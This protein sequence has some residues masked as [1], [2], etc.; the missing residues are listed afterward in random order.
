MSDQPADQDQLTNGI[1]ANGITDS[2]RDLIAMMT[3]G[4]ISELDLT[5]GGVSIRLRGAMAA[6]APASAPSTAVAAP[7]GPIADID[8]PVGHIVTSP[9]IGTFYGAPAPGEAPFVQVGDE[10]EAGQVIGII[11]AMKIMNEI[12][13][14]QSGILAEVIV[15]NAQ[16][17]EFGSP[18]MR[19]TTADTLG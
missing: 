19:I 4:G 15:D 5:A 7:A 1:L 2:V 8:E 16:A 11:E 14:D 12:V 13:A 17:V 18:L 9:M 10:V 6:S 3:R